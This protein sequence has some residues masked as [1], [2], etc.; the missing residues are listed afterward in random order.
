MNR[1]E[2][3]EARKRGIGASDASSIIGANPWKSNVELWEEKTGRREPK[4]LDG[5]IRIEYG[6]SAEAHLRELFALDFP[7]YFVTYDEFAM[8]ANRPD[9]PWLFATLDGELSEKESGGPISMI[10]RNGILEIK[11]TEIMRA[12]QWSEW[13]DRIPQYYYIQLLHQLLATG[14]P[15]AILKAQIKQRDLSDPANPVKTKTYI[16]HYM[17]EASDVQDDMDMLL[18]REIEF[19]DCVQN[20]HRPP[21]LLPPI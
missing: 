21:L 5:E 4:N 2:W 3:L 12:G 18:Q 9:E 1:S 7:M 14:Y 13:N 11:T 10:K 15:F 17:V 16:R 6:K 8:I 20:D 19:W